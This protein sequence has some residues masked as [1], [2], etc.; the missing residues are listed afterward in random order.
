MHLRLFLRCKMSKQYHSIR[1][2]HCTSIALF[3]VA[4][5]ERLSFPSLE[6]EKTAF[7]RSSQ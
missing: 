6:L 7:T 4:V 3:L 5:P 2:L 1:A